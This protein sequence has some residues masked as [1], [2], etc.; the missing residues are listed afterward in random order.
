[1]VPDGKHAEAGGL[2]DVHEVRAGGGLVT[3]LY[4][5]RRILGGIFKKFYLF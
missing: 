5:P 2:G 4:F 3:V 1:M